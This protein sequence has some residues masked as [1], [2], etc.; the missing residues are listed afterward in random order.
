[1]GRTG[2]SPVERVSLYSLRLQLLSARDARAAVVAR[3]AHGLPPTRSLVFL[4]LNVPGE[5]KTSARLDR[6]FGR[7]R[8]ALI[9]PEIRP[10]RISLRGAWVAEEGRDVLGPW[11][12]VTCEETPAAAKHWCMAVEEALS[13][14]RLVDLDVFGGDGRQADRRSLGLP[15][16]RCLVCEQAAVDCIRAGRHAIEDLHGAVGSLLHDAECQ[17][18]ADTL[19]QSARVELEL[20]PK[21]GLVDRQDNG[22]HPDLSYELMSRSIDLL[23]EYYDELIRLA[24][25][26]AKRYGGSAEAGQR[27]TG[28]PC[29]VDLD[30]CVAAGRRAEE[31]M[32]AAIGSNSHRGYIFL[33]GLVLLG[34]AE[35][36]RDEDGKRPASAGLRGGR[37][38]AAR[39]G[40]DACPAPEADERAPGAAV[41][42]LQDSIAGIARQ[43]LT[44]RQPAPG[45]THGADLRARLGIGGIHAEALAGLPS[46]FA[47]GLPALGQAVARFG[48]TD[49]A[50]HYLMAVLMTRVED[51]TALHRC[52]A[53]GLARLRR[54]GRRI[55]AAMDGGDDYLALIAQINQEYRAARLTMG[56]VADCLAITI[57]LAKR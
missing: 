8:A 3:L 48:D 49:G 56:G 15:A 55:V 30:A 42:T 20:T 45:R 19:V 51:T 5:H 32:A 31:R 24:R 22:S 10:D 7:A 37:R 2:V 25:P 1:V 57:A 11:A 38:N 43:I 21:P 47:H 16:R 46:V 9:T 44:P 14:G 39:E 17:S 53:E 4:S 18:L 27:R 36:E 41:S 50:R 34:F 26:R 54:D 29:P 12:A 28:L 33:S 52:G 23:P 35:D 13:A 40:G 6:L